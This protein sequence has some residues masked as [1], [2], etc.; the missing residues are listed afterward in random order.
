MVL[1]SF[2]NEP[3]IIGHDDVYK[4]NIKGRRWAF[5]KYYNDVR[6][7]LTIGFEHQC[8]Y[9]DEWVYGVGYYQLCITKDWKFGYT[10]TYYDYN[11]KSFSL[12]PLHFN[13]A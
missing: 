7:I 8:K 4:T 3:A 12:G 11:H 13:W 1:F 9:E 10:S 2:K 6:E 5:V